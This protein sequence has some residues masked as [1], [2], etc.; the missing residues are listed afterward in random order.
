MDERSGSGPHGLWLTRVLPASRQRLWREWTEPERFAAWFGGPSAV[1]PLA[2]VSMDVRPGGS[3]RATMHVDG[4]EIHWEGAY[5]EVIEP[6]RLVLTFSD[7]PGTEPHEVVT[8]VFTDLGDGMTEMRLE[9][10]GTHPED[11]YEQS[12][13]G[14]SSF[15]DS[16]SERLARDG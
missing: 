6:E 11:L 7:E 8:V 15:L 4:A 2:S 14:W 10:T 9:Q 5:L 1:I 13:A 16:L 3:W 12:L